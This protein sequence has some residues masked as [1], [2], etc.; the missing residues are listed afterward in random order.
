MVFKFGVAYGSFSDWSVYTGNE[1][2]L[3]VAGATFTGTA[4]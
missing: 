4:S 2:T 1:Y 3:A